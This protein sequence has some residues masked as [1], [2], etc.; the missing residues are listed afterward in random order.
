MA[1]PWEKYQATPEASAPWEQYGQAEP[2]PVAQQQ[3]GETS[4]GAATG[5]PMRNVQLNVQNQPRPLEAVGAG[6]VKSMFVD[7]VLGATKLLTGGNVG[8]E[9]SQRYAEEAKPYREA[10]PIGFGVGQVAG[11]LAPASA[12]LKGSSMIPSFAA[13]PLAQ[14]VITGT[15][16]GLLTP[17]ETGKTG[18]D[19]YTQQ[20]KEGAIGATI[21]LV[22]TVGE[23]IG[24]FLRGKPQTPDM[25]AAIDRARA[26]GYVMPPTQAN[27]S[28]LNRTIEGVSGKAATSQN[29][30]ARNQAV[31]NKLA[32]QALGL[33]DDAVLNAQTLQDIRKT[34]GQAYENLGLSG[35]IKTSSKYN[36]ALDD[37]AKEAVQAQKGFPN[38]KP[39]DVIELVNSLKSP[40]F[41]VSAA[42]SKINLLRGDADKAFRQG[43]SALGRATRKAAE[44]LENTIEAHLGNTKQ[45]DLLDKFR[46]ARQLIAKTYSVEKAVNPVTGTVDAK[47]LAAQLSKGKPLSGELKD[48]AEFSARFPKA[49]QTTEAMGSLPQFSPLDYMAG[50]GGSIATQNPA[51]LAAAA[52]RPVLRELA[53]SSPIQNR[54]AQ[55]TQTPSSELARLLM[56]QPANQIIGE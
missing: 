3:F 56:L 55:R 10:S 45:T 34:A 32:A 22:P 14:N 11:S 36:Q 23:K 44:V 38:A 5:R 40:T 26:L 49:T 37:I 46:D 31:T 13:S 2:T 6:A 21:G 50:V 7:P 52:G 18:S 30:S 48:V 25:T 15:T 27:P 51:L 20:A 28:L 4:G 9:A 33:G 41:D 43:D 39:S 1:A 53:L 35:T 8:Q 12:V 47:K 24:S 54:L 19:F 17:Q 16:M 42:M 29:A